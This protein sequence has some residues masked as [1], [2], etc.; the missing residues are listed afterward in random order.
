[1]RRFAMPEQKRMTTRLKELFERPEIFVLAGGMNPMG[2]RMAELLG[3]EAFY[4]SGGNT[5]AHVL[6]WTDSGTSMRDMLD[7]AR[8]IVMTVD[9]PVFA[10]MDTGYGDA[11]SVYRTVKEYIRA[12]IAGA[13]L[14][15]QVYPPKSGSRCRCISTEEMVGKLRAAMDA[16]AEADPDFVIVARCDYAG[17][18]GATFE[19]VME[20]CLAYKR[21]SNVDVI[22]PHVQSWEENTEAIRRIPGPVLPL[23][24]FGSQTH[25]TLGEMQEAGA[26]AAWF[27]GLTTMAGLQASWDFLNDFKERGTG[28]IDRLLAQAARSKWGAVSNGSILGAQRL[29]EMEDKYLPK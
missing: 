13:H 10:D 23:F 14:E 28:A 3:Y 27:P 20:R 21:E 2:A 26:A 1:M 7:N 4:M 6:G 15:D 9:I 17:V 19:E 5:S 11:I 29:R 18:P 12:G 8:R 24:T 22:C 16:K 25:P